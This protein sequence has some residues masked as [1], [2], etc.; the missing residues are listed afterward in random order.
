[1]QRKITVG[2]D[3]GDVRGDSN[4]AIQIA[5]DALGPAGGTVEIL[6]GEYTC[7]DAVHLRTGVRLVGSGERTILRNCPGVCTSVCVDA[8]YG[9]YKVTPKDISGFQPGMRV[10]VRDDRAGGWL[11]STATI[12]RIEGDALHL[13]NH[14]MMDYAMARGAT[15]SNAGALIS[16]IDATDVRI[17]NLVVDGN[18]AT[19]QQ[20]GGCRVG[21]IYLHRVKRA[22][23]TDLLVRDFAGDGISFQITQDVHLSHVRAT[24][25]SNYGIH[26]GTGSARVKMTDCDFSDNDVGGY[27]L[28][29]RVQESTFQRL[30]CDR[31]GQFGISIGHKDTDNT[32]IDCLLCDNGQTALIFRGEIE[33]NGAHRNTWRN[34][35]FSGSPTAILGQAHAYDNLFENCRIGERCQCAAV[36]PVGTKRFVFK[37]CT[38][39]AAVRNEAGPDAG[40]TGL[41]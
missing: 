28:C 25:C 2:I 22:A 24:N 20:A 19:H 21:G 16:A 3:A 33:S 39:K 5:V 40:H 8:D 27:F 18:R 30:R 11:E 34:C 35:E 41:P 4:R 10:Y 7:I 17:E 32:F 12:Q 15:V 36:L 6:P 13:D 1:M 23:L 38:F 9:Q 26:P 14:L 37:D 31:N 29:W